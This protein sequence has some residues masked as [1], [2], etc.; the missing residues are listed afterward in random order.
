VP[1]EKHPSG[2]LKIERLES[3]IMYSFGSNKMKWPK[4]N[5]KNTYYTFVNLDNTRENALA[6]LAI[7]LKILTIPERPI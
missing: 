2:T 4:N 6:K 3:Q 7:Y 1:L 5:S